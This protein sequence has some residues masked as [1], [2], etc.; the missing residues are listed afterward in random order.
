M[1]FQIN[2]NINNRGRDE[3]KQDKIRTCKEQDNLKENTYSVTRPVTRFIDKLAI[4]M[5][6]FECGLNLESRIRTTQITQGSGVPTFRSRKQ[7]ELLSQ[8]L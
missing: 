2:S 8:P 6:A 5:S 7:H 4:N 1:R 3:S